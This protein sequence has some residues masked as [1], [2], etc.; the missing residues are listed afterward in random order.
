MCFRCEDGSRIRP[1]VRLIDKLRS[2]ASEG[3]PFYS[4]EYFPPKTEKGIENLYARIERMGRLGPAFVDVTWGAG[5]STA[6]LTFE[7][8]GTIENVLGIETMM[9]L[10]CTNMPRRRIADVLR[11]CRERGI[12]NI[13]ALRGDPPRGRGAWTPVAD[14]FSH[15]SDL[16]RF[17]REEHGDHFGICV[18]GY[19]EGHPEAPSLDSDLD[20]LARKVAAGADFVITQ[21]FYE[22]EFYFRF[23][24]GCRERGVDCPIVPGLA[25]ITGYLSFQRITGFGA[26]AP[27]EI[28]RE[29]EA[30]R[31]HD[32]SVREYG[33]DLMTGICRR[34]LA[35]GAPGLHF[36]TLNLERSVQVILSRLGILPERSERVLPWRSAAA[37]RRPREDVRPI[38]WANRPKSYLA[39][40]QDWDEFP[41]GR[42]GDSGS[43]AFGDLADH[44]LAFRPVKPTV[45]RQR[46]G[47]EL[48]SIAQVCAVFAAFCRGEV[49]GIPW[50]DWPLDLESEPLRDALV[51][52]NL[53]G[54]LTINSQPRVNGAPSDDPAVG[55]GGS[56]GRVYQKAY[57][58]FFV[59]P[60]RLPPLLAA[61]D[62]K[63]S[64]TYHAI[65]RSGNAR[66][67]CDTVNAVTWG[68]F[69]GREIRQPTIV[70]P[71]SF[72]VWK[73]EALDLWLT[74]WAAVYDE[75]S[76]S[77][78][79]LQRIH[80]TYFLVNVV[81]N[82]YVDGDL[83]G[84]LLE[85][86]QAEEPPSIT[87]VAP[88]T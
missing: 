31:F 50:Y 73:D 28:A 15:A 21:M 3:R 61:L 16:V 81:D 70:D 48:Q 75:G 1:A 43:P 51:R 45:A 59:A 30:R 72:E 84:F 34:L 85:A 25:P 83:L 12:G 40:T 47:R 26:S 17:I 8:A 20:Y 5:G 6:D 24:E 88:V 66:S 38:F 55:W 57:V 64:L 13:L 2:A 77:R 71:R 67:N 74:S 41:N 80:D 52:L 11:D 58:E 76:E 10:T 29:I 35:G 44:H 18:G 56:G 37:V 7:L 53:A 22:P 27:P 63:E 46:W 32:A 33:E 60:E 14:G 4:F 23:V 42:W 86:V 82:D 69:P 62:A 54:L 36:Y 79:L 68:V 9:H 78:R 65:D 87:I 19:P 39:R 49:D